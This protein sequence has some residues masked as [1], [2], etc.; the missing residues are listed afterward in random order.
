MLNFINSWTRGI[1]VAVIITTIIEM[2][3][4]DGNIKKYIRTVMGVFIVFIIISPI[5]TKLT[6]KTFSLT[7]YK[8][9]EVSNKELQTIDTNSY[10]EK[11]YKNTITKD[12]KDS[13]AKKGY[14]VKNIKVSMNTDEENY[15][16]INKIELQIER[17]KE[18]DELDIIE[19]VEININNQ[20]QTVEEIGEEEIGEIKS[21]LSQNYGILKENIYFN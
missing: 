8:L 1:I 15:G 5:V 6:G 2:I 4:P 13:L 10:V 19:P 16:T 14:I 3:L 20:I 7:E 9:P 17:N 11:T 12:I 21:F 18:S